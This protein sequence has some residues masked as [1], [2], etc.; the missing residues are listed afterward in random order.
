MRVRHLWF[1]LIVKTERHC[2]AM[3]VW[4]SMVDTKVCSEVQKARFH[5][6]QIQMYWLFLVS[7]LFL[8]PCDDYSFPKKSS[9]SKVI[10]ST[11]TYESRSSGCCCCLPVRN[12]L[13]LTFRYH[14]LLAFFTIQ[15]FLR[16]FAT[17]RIAKQWLYMHP[18]WLTLKGLHF[19]VCLVCVG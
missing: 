12:Q 10:W 15:L 8:I 18:L 1:Y 17:K 2:L 6:Q 11:F 14:A 3:V 19:F 9:W 4:G 16:V 5:L 13:F 7:L